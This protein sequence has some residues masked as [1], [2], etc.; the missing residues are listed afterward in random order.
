MLSFLSGLWKTLNLVTIYQG[1]IYL[2]ALFW[3]LYCA[4]IKKPTDISELMP[5]FIYTTWVLLLI[6]SPLIAWIGQ[7]LVFNEESAKSV[8]LGWE[9]QW[10]GDAAMFFLAAT[11][12]YT[13]QQSDGHSYIPVFL[14][15]SV[16]AL[17]LSL[18]DLIAVA[19]YHFGPCREKK[20]DCDVIR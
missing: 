10:V 16:N 6:I 13:L 20:L 19:Y 8:L 5:G 14:A 12:S 9:I 11:T 17:L 15:F 1:V 7:F 18:R 3:G 4:L 2:S